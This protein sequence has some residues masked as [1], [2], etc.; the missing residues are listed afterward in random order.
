MSRPA[1]IDIRRQTTKYHRLTDYRMCHGM[2]HAMEPINLEQGIGEFILTVRCTRCQMT[3]YDHLDTS[4]DLSR[5]NY[6]PPPGYRQTAKQTRSE[7]R[8]QYLTA[9]IAETR[10]RR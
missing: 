10:T 3:R 5:R 8:T 4:M 1:S 2:G 7:W 6:K 9:I